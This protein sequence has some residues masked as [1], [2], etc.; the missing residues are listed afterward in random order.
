MKGWTPTQ[1]ILI[2]V[3]GIMVVFVLLRVL[4][5]NQPPV[6]TTPP[7]AAN[8]AGVPHAPFR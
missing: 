6:Q 7:P 8:G 4:E 3:I 1:K 5:L 2:G